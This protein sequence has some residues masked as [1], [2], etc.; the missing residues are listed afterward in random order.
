MPLDQWKNSDVAEAC[1]QI[2]EMCLRHPN[3]VKKF[4]CT[5]CKS[6][7]CRDRHI[8]DHS[9]HKCKDIEDVATDMKVKMKAS[10]ENLQS[11]SNDR[12]T[13]LEEL[14]GRKAALAEK[15][16]DILDIILHHKNAL[17][18]KI[19]EY[20]QDIEKCV[21]TN[22][23]TVYKN[24]DSTIDGSQSENTSLN[25]TID[26]GKGILKFE[27]NSEILNATERLSNIVNLQTSPKL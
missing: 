1:I 27:R 2:K 11:N 10:L 15:E 8:L 22:M 6:A 18:E 24:I 23:A 19:S 16:S 13:V 7:I 17:I 9:D 4:Y 14:S 20:F 3:K 26:L 5:V 21:K 12:R 25:N